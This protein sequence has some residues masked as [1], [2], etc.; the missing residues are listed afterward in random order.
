MSDHKKKSGVFALS[1][2]ML[3]TDKPGQITSTM[4][5][6]VYE[7]YLTRYLLH[8]GASTDAKNLAAIKHCIP[9]SRVK[10]TAAF[11]SRGSL[12]D[13][14]H[15]QQ[16]EAD[17]AQQLDWKGQNTQG[18]LAHKAVQ[19]L[20]PVADRA[21][22]EL[23]R[24]TAFMPSGERAAQP[25]TE[26]QFAARF[27][28]AL[29]ASTGPPAQQS[30]RGVASGRSA[31]ASTPGSV[32]QRDMVPVRGDGVFQELAVPCLISLVDILAVQT[33]FARSFPLSLFD[34][35]LSAEDEAATVT[36][37]MSMQVLRCCAAPC[38]PA[39]R[40]LAAPLAHCIAAH[41]PCSSLGYCKA[42]S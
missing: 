40:P 13:T 19:A 26:Q 36:L 1:I 37:L 27:G 6:S 7:E 9:K 35:K 20:K 32:S 10:L 21:T 30:A 12:E 28:R 29:K 22:P 17:R 39:S 15:V 42:C 33:M 34:K 8:I 14:M 16:Q 5:Q 24:P 3:P 2:P 41:T 25:D 4:Q 23:S 18:Y 38:S 31:A 11:K